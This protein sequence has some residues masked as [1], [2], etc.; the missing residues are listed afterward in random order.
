MGQKKRSKKPVTSSESV[1]E[2]VEKKQNSLYNQ[3]APIS[4]STH[5]PLETQQHVETDSPQ[6]QLVTMKVDEKIEVVEQNN[7]NNTIDTGLV[8]ALE[9]LVDLK[10][11]GFLTQEEFT[12][13][14]ENL[15]QSLFEKPK[16]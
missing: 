8:N 14:K 5:V 9:K 13:A 11:Q 4:P 1:V 7:Q 16:E 10:Q 2:L 3:P 15:M 12:K 6:E